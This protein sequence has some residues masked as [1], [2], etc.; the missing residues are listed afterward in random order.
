MSSPTQLI[1][2]AFPKLTN[3]TF[4]VTSPPT[5]QY[6]CIAW[7]A[8]DDT[9]WWWPAPFAGPPLGGYYWPAGLPLT[10]TL[11]NFVQAFRRQGYRECEDGS[12]EE[13]YEKI[14]L[15]VDADGVPTHAAR[16][17][18]DG[19]WTSKLGESHDISHAEADGIECPTYGMVGQFMR[20][21]IREDRPG[22]GATDIAF[23]S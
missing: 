1:L 6:N 7:A 20:R 2:A 17:L 8:G 5:T 22:P 12:L 16:Q 4:T 15:Y 19:Q 9:S 10:V 11:D 18:A 13:G 23:L 14:A 3:G 21:P